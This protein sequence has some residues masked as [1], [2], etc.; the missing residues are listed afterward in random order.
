[1]LHSGQGPAAEHGVSI[2]SKPELARALYKTTEVGQ[3]IPL[4][5]QP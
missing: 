2:L 3:E 5:I 1:M 4:F